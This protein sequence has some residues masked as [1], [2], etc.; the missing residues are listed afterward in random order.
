MDSSLW[1]F[2]I[3]LCGIYGLGSVRIGGITSV[4][5]LVGLGSLVKYFK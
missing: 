3:L 1:T 5:S 2:K 4:L